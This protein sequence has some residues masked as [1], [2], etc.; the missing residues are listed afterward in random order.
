[1]GF[2]YNICLHFSSYF[3]G[4]ILSM[5]LG[6]GRSAALN[7][8]VNTAVGN[9]MVVVTASGND[10]ID[11]CQSS[12]GSAGSNINVG[13]HGYDEDSCGK[14]RAYFS[15]YGTC[16]DIMAPGVAILS[17]THTSNTGLDKLNHF[18]SFNSSF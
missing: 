3:V 16:V 14:P 18:S 4:S 15:D 9:G 2:Q 17:A 11:A 1:M 8:A 6:G 12:P 7:A 5:S 13:A 10:D